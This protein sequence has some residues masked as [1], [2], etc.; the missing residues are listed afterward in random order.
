MVLL[1]KDRRHNHLVLSELNR[2]SRQISCIRTNGLLQL[3]I[4]HYCHHLKRPIEYRRSRDQE[5]PH[6]RLITSNHPMVQSWTLLSVGRDA[7]YY[8]L[9]LEVKL[10]RLSLNRYH[11]MRLDRRSQ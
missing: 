9:I 3:T 7:L 10:L 2:K 8:L 1:F 5:R 11:D 4:T 6:Q